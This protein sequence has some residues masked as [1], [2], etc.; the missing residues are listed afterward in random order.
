M[1]S[2]AFLHTTS[3]FGTRF[4][5]DLI[6]FCLYRNPFH[7]PWKTF[8]KHHCSA[9]IRAFVIVVGHYFSHEEG[10]G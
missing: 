2:L 3:S 1:F 5:F 6:R 9:S 4:P 7:F 8:L 10:A